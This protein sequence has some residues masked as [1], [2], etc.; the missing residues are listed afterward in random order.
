MRNIRTAAS[1]KERRSGPMPFRLSFQRLLSDPRAAGSL[2]VPTSIE[3]LALSSL[4]AFYWLADELFEDSADEI[5]NVVGPLAFTA[6]M[7]LA[8][9]HMLQGDARVV[10]TPLFTF[11]VSSAVYFGIGSLVHLIIDPERRAILELF[12]QFSDREVAKVNL[13]TACS[14]LVI[15]VVSGGL[16]G[17]FP[18]RRIVSATA[19]SKMP[20]A[21]ANRM[22]N[23]GL[24]FV[25]IGST[26]K[27]LVVFPM[28]MGW[29]AWGKVPGSIVVMAEMSL[30]GLC[31]LTI[32]SLSYAPKLF[33]FVCGLVT[34]EMLVGVVQFTKLQVLLPILMLLVGMYVHK[35]T[36]ARIVLGLLVVAFTIEFMQPLVSYARDEFNARTGGNREH[37]SIGIRFEILASYF[38]PF[39]RRYS[40]EAAGEGLMRICYVN[41]ATFAISQYDRGLAGNSFRNLAIALVPR[42]LW[43]DK[44]LLQEGGEF[45]TAAA[46]FDV[47]NSVS[48]GLYAEAYWNFG[49]FGVP[50]VMP[51][52][53]VFL[54]MM[55]RY[56]LW[57]LREE[58]WIFFPIALIGMKLGLSMDMMFV[59]LF[60]GT[61]AII[62]VLHFGTVMVEAA[63]LRLGLD[64]AARS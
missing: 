60:A 49:W 44:P 35:L 32:W 52:I 40:N 17:L 24:A 33:P 28:S 10:F 22:R 6:I 48:P 13:L 36:W 56:S 59:S 7:G 18:A 34:I 14:A 23:Y 29:V 53:S 2:L 26:L 5:V 62:I 57:I 19:T 55:S 27:Y 31:L 1:I 8:A 51:V 47:Q 64:A 12:Y 9:L 38:D 54:T 3:I 45:A 11:R 63:L 46:G 25:I 42:V 16:E 39:R 41:A 61:G 4:V 20:M 50:V 21:R 43:P 15:V 58:R 37:A 30:I